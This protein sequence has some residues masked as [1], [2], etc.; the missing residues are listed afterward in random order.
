[1]NSVGETY[2]DI[3]IIIIIIIIKLL[4]LLFSITW[5]RPPSWRRILTGN[6]I[7]ISV[8]INKIF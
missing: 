8:E 2:T 6:D 7:I 3:I 1:M 5:K 4:L